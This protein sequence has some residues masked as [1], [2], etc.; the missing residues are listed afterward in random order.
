MIGIQNMPLFKAY[1]LISLEMNANFKILIFISLPTLYFRTQA[2]HELVLKSIWNFKILNTF[3]GPH[4]TKI[5]PEST[6][7]ITYL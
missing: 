2:V 7:G 6:F 4:K 3:R 5:V 1:I